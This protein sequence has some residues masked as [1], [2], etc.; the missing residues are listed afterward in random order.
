MTF[1]IKFKNNDKVFEIPLNNY[2]DSFFNCKYRFDNQSSCV[3]DNY[4]PTEFQI[5]YDVILGQK[6]DM[7]TYVKN[8]EIF[9][10]FGITNEAYENANQ[11]ILKMYNKN[12]NIASDFISNKEKIFMPNSLDDYLNYKKI[13][14]QFDNIIP[15]ALMNIEINSN[16]KVL[17]LFAYEGYPVCT[18]YHKYKDVEDF[19]DY[20]EYNKTLAFTR[21]ELVIELLAEFYDLSCDEYKDEIYE[22]FKDDLD[23]I[24]MNSIETT[25]YSNIMDL[26]HDAHVRKIND[27]L[28]DIQIIDIHKNMIVPNSNIECKSKKFPNKKKSMVE[29]S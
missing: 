2:P 26:F 14:F 21:K 16:T 8:S 6:I 25:F 19:I 4:T 22:N 24:D 18:I 20:Q 27:K 9:N 13:F 17:V 7:L 15:F 28:I 23:D 1:I 11:K 29:I 12:L 10:Y 3:I 5:V